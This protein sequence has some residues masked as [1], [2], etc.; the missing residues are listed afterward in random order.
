MTPQQRIEFKQQQ[1][2]QALKKPLT[3]KRTNKYN[4]LRGVVRIS[5]Y[6]NQPWRGFT[7]QRGHFYGQDI[8]GDYFVSSYEPGFNPN[9]IVV[10][11]RAE[12][13]GV[14]ERLELPRDDELCML[15]AKA[16]P[17][18]SVMGISKVEHQPDEL[19]RKHEKIQFQNT[20]PKY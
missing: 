8:T 4:S 18:R 2:L 17:K 9:T 12:F 1:T 7:L 20:I 11:A 3:Q 15:I 6:Y 10:Y 13:N 16:I 5:Q 14:W 19:M